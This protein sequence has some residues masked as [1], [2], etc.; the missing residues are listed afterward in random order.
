[1]TFQFK[2]G[3]KRLD[4]M[5]LNMLPTLSMADDPPLTGWVNGL[6]ASDLEERF[7]R[8]LRREKYE[9]RFKVLISTPFNLPGEK[10]EVDFIVDTIDQPVEIDGEI[11][12]RTGAQKEKDKVRDVIL[13][14]VLNNMGLKNIERI[15]WHNLEDQEEAYLSVRML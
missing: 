9:F 10:N 8:A 7:A 11:G 3:S 14:P 5:D 15:S 1:M 13:N 12:H 4:R 2:I 6:E